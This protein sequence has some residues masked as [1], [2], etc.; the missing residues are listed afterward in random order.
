VSRGCAAGTG[1]QAGLGATYRAGFTWG[2]EHGYQALVEMDADLSHPA[3]RLPALLDGLALAD[4]VIG[5]RYVP[6]GRRRSRPRHP[7]SVALDQR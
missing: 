6:G 1:A 2:L 4:L 5:S 7:Q 3:D